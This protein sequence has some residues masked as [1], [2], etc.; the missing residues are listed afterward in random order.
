MRPH[1]SG[2][3]HVSFSKQDAFHLSPKASGANVRWANAN[4]TYLT[5]KDPRTDTFLRDISPAKLRSTARVWNPQG[6]SNCE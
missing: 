6:I 5:H 4:N 1:I 2:T 3:E